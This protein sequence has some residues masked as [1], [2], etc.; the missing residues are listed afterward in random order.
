MDGAGWG[1]EGGHSAGRAEID[2]V[3]SVLSGVIACTSA[4]RALLGRAL[5]VET[6]AHIILDVRA[7]V[8]DINNM[9]VVADTINS[10]RIQITDMIWTRKNFDSFV[11]TPLVEQLQHGRRGYCGESTPS[12]LACRDPPTDCH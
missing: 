5:S 3:F 2:H 6:V 10:L 4:L 8:N 9:E 7:L 11:F 1:Q 12:V